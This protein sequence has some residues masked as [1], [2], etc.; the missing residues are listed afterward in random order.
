MQWKLPCDPYLLSI[1]GFQQGLFHLHNPDHAYKNIIMLEYIK[2]KD[3]QAFIN[4]IYWWQMH[5]SYIT[6]AYRESHSSHRPLHSLCSIKSSS[7]LVSIKWTSALTYLL[8]HKWILTFSPVLPMTPISP[9]SPLRPMSPFIEQKKLKPLISHN[10]L[11]WHTWSPCGPEMPSNPGGPGG[12]CNPCNNVH[13][14]MYKYSHWMFKYQT[15]RKYCI[16]KT[17]NM[18]AILL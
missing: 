14:N 18:L 6:M 8:R 5:S 1:P 2:H 3:R 11:M 17:Y 12:P 13:L 16:Y 9:L 10:I 7:S 15:W 4:N